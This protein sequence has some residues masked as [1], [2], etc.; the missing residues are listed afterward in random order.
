[1]VIH[2]LGHVRDSCHGKTD[3][4]RL[5][6]ERTEFPY[7]L[8]YSTDIAVPCTIIILTDYTYNFEHWITDLELCALPPS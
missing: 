1:M 7:L 2:D 5:F 3:G 8:R 6:R 4:D